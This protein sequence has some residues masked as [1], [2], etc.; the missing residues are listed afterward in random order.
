MTVVTKVVLWVDWKVY[1]LVALTVEN[2]A[3][4]KD[5]LKVEKLVALMV[6]LKA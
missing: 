1:E 3:A 4:P 2:L 5:T 6:E